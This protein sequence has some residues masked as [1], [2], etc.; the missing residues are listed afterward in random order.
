MKRFVIACMFL[1]PAVLFAQND[2]AINTPANT[3]KKRVLENTE[4]DILTSFYT[5]DGKNAAVTGGIG[6]E[7]LNDFT[8]N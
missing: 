1:F 4:I 7:K 6:T 8:S 2:T 3:Y 5:Q